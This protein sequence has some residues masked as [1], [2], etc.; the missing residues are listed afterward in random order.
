[1]SEIKNLELTKE[2]RQR[3]LDNIIDLEF[4]INSHW[5]IIFELRKRS[6]QNI[7]KQNLL[8][9][10]VDNKRNEINK[11]RVVLINNKFNFIDSKNLI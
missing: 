5:N 3:L 4:D 2:N 10:E 7:A 8:L 9:F 6:D 11:I 1:M